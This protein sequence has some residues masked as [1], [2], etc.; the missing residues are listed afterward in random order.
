MRS[1]YGSPDWHTA[2][3][4]GAPADVIVTH[5]RQAGSS[6][7]VMATSG[8]SGLKRIFEGKV[9][10]EVSRKAETPVLLVPVVED[11]F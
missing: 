8:S 5:A 3:V 9:T 11:E 4:R 10:E 7:I 6:L 1:T 2:V